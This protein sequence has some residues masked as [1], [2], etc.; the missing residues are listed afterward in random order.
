MSSVTVCN[1]PQN[2]LDPACVRAVSSRQFDQQQKK[3]DGRTCWAGG[4]GCRLDGCWPN[5]GT[6]GKQC[7][8]L[9]C[10]GRSD[11]DELGYAAHKCFF[12]IWHWRCWLFVRSCEASKLTRKLWGECNA[13]TMHVLANK[14]KSHYFCTTQLL[15][16]RTSCVY[17]GLPNSI[18]INWM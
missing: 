10:S 18:P 11:T 7:Q 9:A 12:D 6:G 4:V 15:T 3:P 5:A 16:V 17:Q 14:Q 8:K 2:T 13:R 1:C